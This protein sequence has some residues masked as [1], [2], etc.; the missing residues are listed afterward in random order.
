MRHERL[1]AMGY[2]VIV[3]GVGVAGGATATPIANAPNP[4]AVQEVVSGQRGEANAAWWGFN[5]EDVTE[6]LQAALDS[7]AKRLVVPFM[8]AD[9]IVRPLT[10]RGNQ[11]IVFEPGV[12]VLAKKDEFKAT[13]DSLFSATNVS[14]ITL[15]GY[16]ATLRMRHQDYMTKAYKKGEWR[17]TLDFDGCR[18]ITVEGLRLES[19]GGDGIYLGA[20]SELAWCE[21]VV[22][23]DVVCDDHH[24]QGISV[25]GA[26]N[27]LIEN[28]ILS[29][30]GGTAPQAGIDFEPNQARERL[31]NCVMRNCTLANNRGAGI[32]LYLK[33]LS[34]E[35]EPVSLLFENCHVVGGA[36]CGIGVGMLDDD[37]PQG[38]IEFRNC[39]IDGPARAG[40]YLYDKSAGSARLRFVNC[41]WRNAWSGSR[42]KKNIR[43]PLLIHRRRPEAVEAL[44][45]IDFVDC[46]VYDTDDRPVLLVENEKA[47]VSVRDLQ[48]TIVV[49]SPYRVRME[50]G[51]NPKDVGLS[52]ESAV[53]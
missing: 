4:A 44:G 39:T 32:L 40:A 19:S 48:G 43:V 8:G 23:R 29:N 17:M 24:R 10:L 25:I 7:G 41:H 38:S 18:K 33:N 15:R 27:L 51:Q 28:C 53:Q 1:W 36:D 2:W 50:L 45:G 3:F 26:V 16:G 35:S 9:W 47:A 22:I 20:T 21:D 6:S 37:A 34:K 49:H 46:H 5:P 52:L 12:V 11:E 30:T 14:N 42:G 13:G 31:V